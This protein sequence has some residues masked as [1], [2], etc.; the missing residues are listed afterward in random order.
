MLKRPLIDFA[1]RHAKNGLLVVVNN[2]SKCRSLVRPLPSN[3]LFHVSNRNFSDRAMGF[4]P[5]APASYNI[6]NPDSKQI[7]TE[8]DVEIAGNIFLAQSSK[9][10][11]LGEFRVEAL[12]N[13]LLTL[14]EAATGE[15]KLDLWLVD[16]LSAICNNIDSNR[17][18]SDETNLTDEIRELNKL[19]NY[20]RDRGMNM[21]EIDQ[22]QWN[23]FL[24]DLGAEIEQSL[25]MFPPEQCFYG[26]RD[27][28][29]T[30]SPTIRDD[31]KY[32]LDTLNTEQEMKNDT[33]N[34]LF[35][36]AV[37]RQ[38]L[39]Q[40]REVLSDL[41]NDWKKLINLT[42]QDIDRA[43]VQGKSAD[44]FK[45]LPTAKL[46]SLLESY[47]VGNCVDRF[48][49]LWNLMDKDDDGLLDEVEVN[50]VCDMAIGTIGSALL[51]TLKEVVEASP[52]DNVDD[53]LTATVP[54]TNPTRKEK[55]LKK[56]LVKL[57]KTTTLT[58]HF[59]DELELSHRVRCSYAWANKEHQKNRIESVLVDDVGWNGR[60]R[61]V[62]LKPKI[63]LSEF[64]EV[65]AEHMK[66]LDRI[67]VE[68]LKSYREELLF[69]QGKGRQSRE[70]NRDCFLFMAAI[71]L[72]DYVIWLL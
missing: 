32:L 8:K 66:F 44:A 21:A 70:T 69:I 54:N 35:Q 23:S 16:G 59:S 42:D 53:T 49:A 72:T 6:L 60:K 12:A 25:Q 41:K 11:K 67:S 22:S 10:E 29:D 18:V 58:S 9:R 39:L 64:R 26:I 14:D 37:A 57:F 4:S 62:E 61:H 2:S 51:S 33:I 55:G 40:T 31:E 38:R 71:C 36:K 34:S 3:G 56:R 15:E 13:N 43:A 65:Q 17:V 68:Y 27:L 46:T 52:L 50:S 24:H 20:C 19:V 63:S 28:L 47:L 30:A 1:S 5:M 45:T 48:D 7:P